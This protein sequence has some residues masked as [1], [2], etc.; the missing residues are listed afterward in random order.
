MVTKTDDG[1]TSLVTSVGP[2][3]VAL[4]VSG[5]ITSTSVINSQETDSSGSS[6]GSGSSPS[7]SGAAAGKGKPDVGVMLMG[8]LLTGVVAVAGFL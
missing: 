2:A 4:A 8:A 5:D 1:T 7:D 6:G 3:T